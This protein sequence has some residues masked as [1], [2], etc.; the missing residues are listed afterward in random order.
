MEYLDT[1]YVIA[2]AVVNDVN[3]EKAV[4]ISKEL[5]DPV[6]SSLTTLE[7]YAYYS[8]NPDKKLLSTMRD[9]GLTA[10]SSVRYSLKKAN[11]REIKVQFDEII[12]KA[13]DLSVEFRLKT[14]DLIHVTIAVSIGA[15]KLITFDKDL[16][17]LR[18]RLRNNYSID[19][20]S[21]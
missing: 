14:L 20:I 3:H 8:R 13:R 21:A 17:K 16:L 10:E 19:V 4:E 7:L 5:R 18:D 2:L 15:S 6:V 11:A 1:S 9:L 12:Y